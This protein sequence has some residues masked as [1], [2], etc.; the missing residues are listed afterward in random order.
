[1]NLQKKAEQ[2]GLK[3]AEYSEDLNNAIAQKA[4]LMYKSRSVVR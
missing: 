2:M 4:V 3:P 1:M